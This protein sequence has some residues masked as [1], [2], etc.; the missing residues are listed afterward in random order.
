MKFTKIFVDEKGET[1]FKDVK[2]ELESVI[3]A[4]PAP[5]FMVSKFRPATK[6]AFTRFPSGWFGDWHPA[7]KKQVYFILTGELECRVS[8]GERRIFGPG[9]IVQVEDTTGKGHVT[10]V[11]S[12]EDV[13]TAVVQVEN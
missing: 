6:F 1:H 7:P 12:S 4:P 8:D 11:E 3:F 2:I 5:A 10:R 13:V 9:S